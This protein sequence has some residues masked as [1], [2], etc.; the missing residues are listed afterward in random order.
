M[1]SGDDSGLTAILF[2]KE[3]WTLTVWSCDAA[4]NTL[5][6]VSETG[7]CTCPLW[8]SVDTVITHH[9]LALWLLLIQALQIPDR[10]L[11]WSWHLYCM[12]NIAT[13]PM[14]A[15]PAL[16][17]AG[18]KIAFCSQNS[19]HNVPNDSSFYIQI[20]SGQLKMDEFTNS[21][22]W[23]CSMELLTNDCLLNES[24]MYFVLTI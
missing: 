1:N 20:Y 15:R 7:G 3:Q 12:G 5:G 4:V 18:M 6:S 19:Q 22:F 21:T 8:L 2:T 24:V 11:Q 10:C 23:V 16:V 14:A 9:S 13:D 17:T